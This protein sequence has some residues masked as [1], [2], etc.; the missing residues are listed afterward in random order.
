MGEPEETKPC[1]NCH[2]ETKTKH[3]HKRQKSTHDSSEEIGDTFLCAFC[4]KHIETV[5]DY[6]ACSGVSSVGEDVFERYI[7]SFDAVMEELCCKVEVAC[8][9]PPGTINHLAIIIYTG[10]DLCVKHWNDRDNC[11]CRG[12]HL[13]Y[14]VD[15]LRH[16]Y[17]S[18]EDMQANNSVHLMSPVAT[19]SVG[20]TRVLH[21]KFTT[22]EPKKVS[23]RMH[24]MVNLN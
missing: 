22:T 16:G 5:A 14:H 23:E 1:N 19:V 12:R 21:M 8:N 20:D 7:G 6:A 11:D 15:I 3:T 18:L 13:G 24:E 10:K 17:L 9:L 2:T 4:K